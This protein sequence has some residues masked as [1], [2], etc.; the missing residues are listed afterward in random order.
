LRVL[1][2]QELLDVSEGVFDRPAA[3]VA[4]CHLLGVVVEVGGE[5]EV[6]VL[7]GFGVP[8]DDEEDLTVRA[9]LVPEDGAEEEKALFETAPEIDGLAGPAFGAAGH[10]LGRGH[11]PTALPRT[12]SR[13]ALP[14]WRQLEEGGVTPHA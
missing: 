12:P 10:F 5:E 1:A 7:F 14:G 13:P 8:D 3:G 11:A 6:V 4:A 9:D 2:S